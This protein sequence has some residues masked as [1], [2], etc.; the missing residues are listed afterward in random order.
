VVIGDK[1]GNGE[2]IPLGFRTMEA[3]QPVGYTLKSIVVKNVEGNRAKRNLQ[4]LWRQRA[5]RGK[6]YIFKHEYILFFQKTEFVTSFRKIIEFAKAIDDREELDLIRDS[7]FVSGE[8]LGVSVQSPRTETRR[9]DTGNYS[10]PDRRYNKTRYRKRT[11]RLYQPAT[12]E[13][14]GCIYVG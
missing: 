8:E 10:R 7:S 6:Y 1:Y 3:V 11:G 4:N 5:L 9:A 2:W 13:S 12:S 14:C